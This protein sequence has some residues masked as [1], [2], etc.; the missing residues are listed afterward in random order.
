MFVSAPPSRT[1]VAAALGLL[2]PALTCA[3]SPPPLL[4][5]QDWLDELPIVLSASRLPQPAENTPMAT[6][7]IDRQMIEASGF[8][9]VP[10]LLRLAPGFIVNYE[11]G[12]VQAVGYHMLID[13]YS[14][15]M[16]VLVDGRS[17]YEPALGGVPWTDLPLAIE[18]IERIEVIRGPN[19]ASFGA[20]SFTAVINIITRQAVLDQG[21]MTKINLG[22]QRMGEA[23]L[24]YGGS[25]GSLDYRVTAAYR[26][27][28]GFDDRNDDMQVKLLTLRGDYQLGL[29]DS[30][31]L[32]L[33]HN[34]GSKARDNVFDELVPE[35]TRQTYSQFQQLRWTHALS[36]DNEFTLQIYHNQ[37]KDLNDYTTTPIVALGGVQVYTDARITSNRWDAEFQHILRP[38]R[39]LRLIWGA[40]IRRDSV[41]APL[42]FATGSDV[43]NDSW[44]L[45]SNAEYRPHKRVLVN[46]GVMLE[47]SDT[48][49]TS[50]SPRA[51][52]NYRFMPNH[53]LRLAASR[54]YRDP[55][56][57]EESPDYRFPLAI[58]NNVLLFDAGNI[59]PERITS[60]DI[61]YVGNFPA[62]HTSIDAKYFRERLDKLITYN[63]TP[64]PLGL[65]G[66]ALFFSNDARARISGVELSA[67]Y[68][69][70]RANRFNISYTHL[71]IESDDRNNS[72]A[73]S[74]A[75]PDNMLNLLAIHEFGGGYSGSAAYYYL[76]SMKELE[77][78]GI[79]ASQHRVDA[80]LARHWSPGGRNITLALVVQNLF[81]DDEDTRLRNNIDRRVYGS[82]RIGIK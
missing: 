80:R 1:R 66:K 45:F 17:V 30:L 23:Y 3:G 44:R 20:N 42:F 62:I 74:D 39:P 4:S 78:R 38:T 54:A 13:R 16:Q 22:E 68:R 24:R 52:I 76:S 43:E 48:G 64:H 50:V 15:Q 79:R 72:G 2:L 8:T 65:D 70:N 63:N 12:Y 57:F 18:D 36:A 25:E 40:G 56:V 11:N 6:T 47:N 61:G 75:G 35:Y 49:D 67:S 82:I 69:P 59:D 28:S 32:Q 77:S 51:S 41:N 31:M 73:F 9:E 26:E 29:N 19:A 10:D 34:S 14:R 21:L 5:E 7:I 81:N 60:L 46:A 53:T 27:N 55:F 33:G 37:N 71:D 58:P